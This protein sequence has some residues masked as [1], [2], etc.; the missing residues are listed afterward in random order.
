MIRIVLRLVFRFN[1]R[2]HKWLVCRLN[3]LLHRWL[4]FLLSNH[5][6]GSTHTTGSPH[7]IVGGR[8]IRIDL[9]GCRDGDICRSLT[10]INRNGRWNVFV[11]AVCHKL[12]LG[13]HTGLVVDIA[14]LGKS[15]EPENDFSLFRDF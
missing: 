13:F 12:G 4:I 14:L 6:T 2:L 7:T 9:H 8:D 10:T 1:G 11:H 5:A 3:R 15:A